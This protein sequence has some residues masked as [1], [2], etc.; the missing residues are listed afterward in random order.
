MDFLRD[1][2]FL[3]VQEVKR[4]TRQNEIGSDGLSGDN[5]NLVLG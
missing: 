2:N 4:H 1:L 3:I 5:R